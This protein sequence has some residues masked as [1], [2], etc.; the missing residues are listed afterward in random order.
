MRKGLSSA[1]LDN[2][3]SMKNPAETV[4]ESGCIANG[5]PHTQCLCFHE[6]QS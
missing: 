1:G 4:K 6:V 3:T 5:T 2:D